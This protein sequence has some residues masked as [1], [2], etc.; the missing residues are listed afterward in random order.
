MDHNFLEVNLAFLVPHF[1]PPDK[2]DS[3][4]ET[5]DCTQA[6]IL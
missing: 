6:E 2:Q 1:R 5:Y 4:S 3:A